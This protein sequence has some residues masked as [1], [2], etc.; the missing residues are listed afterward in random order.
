MQ[1]GSDLGYGAT[2]GDLPW[3]PDPNILT[4]KSPCEQGSG[5]HRARVR[6]SANIAGRSDYTHDRHRAGESQDRPAEPRLQYPP[7]R[8][9][10]A[11]GGRITERPSE[12][13]RMG[14]LPQKPRRTRVKSTTKLPACHSDGRTNNKIVIVRGALQ[15]KTGNLTHS[16]RKPEFARDDGLFTVLRKCTAKVVSR[17]GAFCPKN[18]STSQSEWLA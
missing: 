6:C 1:T 5:S 15:L 10:G 8:D 4:H 7:A 18:L 14:R 9:A 12:V 11:D 2:T 3:N 16:V 17:T 13:S